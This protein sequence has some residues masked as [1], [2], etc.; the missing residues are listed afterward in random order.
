MEGMKLKKKHIGQAFD[1]RGGDG[2]WF[3]ILCDI[4]KKDLLFY[5][6][7]GKYYIDTN[8]YADWRPFVA[9]DNSKAALMMAWELAAENPRGN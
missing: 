6:S 1:V 7:N 5:S 2:S 3:Y 9:V 8:R 4:H